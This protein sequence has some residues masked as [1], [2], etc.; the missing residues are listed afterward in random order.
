MQKDFGNTPIVLSLS[1]HDPSGAAGIQAD[2]E[3]AASLGC[4][5]A[6]ILTSLCS[7]DTGTTSDM[8]PVDAELLIRQTRAILEDMPV[9]VIKLGFLGTVENIEAVHSILIDYP[10]IPVVFDPITWVCPSSQ[11]DA[12]GLRQAIR[13]LILPLTTLTTTD[14]V[15][16]HDLAQQADTLDACAQSILDSG[17]QYLLISGAQ[18]THDYYVNHFFDH[19]G[20]IKA[21]QWQRLQIFSHGC[22]ATL[23]ASIACYLAHGLL[24]Q[25]A[26]EQGQRFTWQALAHSRRLGMGRRIP[27]RLF[28]ADENN[29]N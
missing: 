29:S 25:D 20:L 10:D 14:S 21:Y 15:E 6:T 3:T 23:S 17:C 18:R 13:H 8:V 5:T 4:H 1:S 26:L 19:R 11:R 2:I 24:L 28:W 22:G 7:K 27:N 12:P 16:A 9:G